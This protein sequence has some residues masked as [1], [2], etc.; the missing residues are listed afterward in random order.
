MQLL[1]QIIVNRVNRALVYSL[2]ARCRVTT[3]ETYG[4]HAI[5]LIGDRSQQRWL[6][7]GT[8]AFIT[9]I[10]ISVYW[11]VLIS[12]SLH[13]LHEQSL[14][15]TCAFSIW[16][17][18]RLQISERYEQINLVWDRCEKVIY[19]VVDLLL[20]LLFIRTVSARLVSN[21]LERYRPLLRTNTR[22]I[23]LSIGMDA[24]IIGAMSLRNSF[25]YM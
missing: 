17:P 23:V 15:P 2:F 21:G 10:N 9:A 20:N 12:S 24:F 1:L 5:V 8:A 14:T 7:Y 11:Y 19:L 22:L 25:V 16:I 6:K 13:R 3:A 4:Y 18:A